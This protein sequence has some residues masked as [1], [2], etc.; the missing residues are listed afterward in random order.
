MIGKFLKSWQ[1]WFISNNRQTNEYKIENISKFD[2]PVNF[3]DY[4]HCLPLP[5]DFK[6]NPQKTGNIALFEVP[7]KPAWEDSKNANGFMFLIKVDPDAVDEVW[8]NLLFGVVGNELQSKIKE[9][10][11]DVNINGVLF[12]SKFG[13]NK[14]SYHYRL[15]IWFSQISSKID[16]F[17]PKFKSFLAEYLSLRH[18]ESITHK[19][20]NNAP[21]KQQK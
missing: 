13:D 21:K 10:G 17:L 9:F 18:P 15:E 19:L 16:E 20:H 8:K 4:L 11:F 3:I 7:I 12:A 5:S 2:D 6:P 1:F 14:N